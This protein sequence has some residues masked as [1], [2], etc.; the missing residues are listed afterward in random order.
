MSESRVL[1]GTE[2]SGRQSA[3]VGTAFAL[4]GPPEASSIDNGR[5]KR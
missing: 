1:R 3:R 4:L 5:H 2:Q